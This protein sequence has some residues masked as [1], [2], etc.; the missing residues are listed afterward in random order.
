MKELLIYQPLTRGDSHSIIN[1]TP[2]CKFIY[3]AKC[4]N[5]LNELLQGEGKTY[6][7]AAGCFI[8]S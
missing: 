7:I 6:I 4:S 3:A 8:Q 2:D 5:P 1:F